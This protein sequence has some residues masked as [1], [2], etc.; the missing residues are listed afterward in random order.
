MVS[1]LAVKALCYYHHQHVKLWPKTRGTRHGGTLTPPH[2][3]AAADRQSTRERQWLRELHLPDGRVRCV[4]LHVGLLRRRHTH[5]QQDTPAINTHAEQ[6]ILQAPFITYL[7]T[8]LSI[9]QSSYLS[10]Y[11]SISTYTH[12]HTHKPTHL[13]QHTRKTNPKNQGEKER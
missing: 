3:R 5:L 9:Y 7:L 11:L 8:Y 13:T 4:Q 2:T 10:I 12:P 1:V 6:N